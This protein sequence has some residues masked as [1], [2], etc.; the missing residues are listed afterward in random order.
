MTDKTAHPTDPSVL[1]SRLECARILKSTPG[2]SSTT[3][4]WPWP[5]SCELPSRST[6]PQ[7]T[8]LASPDL[9]KTSSHLVQAL[10]DQQDDGLLAAARHRLEEVAARAETEAPVTAGVV[11]RSSTPSPPSVFEIQVA[12]RLENLPHRLLQPLTAP[13]PHPQRPQLARLDLVLRAVSLPL[14]RRRS[15]VSSR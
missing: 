4:S 14:D 8:V 3:P 2:T 7:P 10:L 11:R 12:P 15:T 1:Q 9:P 5:T 6:S 13:E